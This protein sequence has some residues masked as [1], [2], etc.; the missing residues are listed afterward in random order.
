MHVLVIQN[1]PHSPVSLAGDVMKEQGAALD[2]VLPHHGGSLPR[3]AGSHDAAIILG[4]AAPATMPYPA[5]PRRS[6]A[7]RLPP[8]RSRLGLC[9]GRCWPAPS[10]GK[11]AGTT[12]SNGASRRCA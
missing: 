12:R 4:G 9:L 10:A 3:N 2:V 6:S 11:C 7:A 8:S 5:F 1:D